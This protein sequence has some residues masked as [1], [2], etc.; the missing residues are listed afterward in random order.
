MVR[1]VP[2]I[3]VRIDAFLAHAADLPEVVSVSSPSM[4]GGVSEDGTVAYA[5]V[6]YA[7]AASDVATESVDALTGLIDSSDGDGLR[8]ETGGAVITNTERS[9]PGES[10]LISIAAA[11]IILLLTFGSVVA[12]G[13]PIVTALIGVAIG[14]AL[15]AISAA[16]LDMATLTTAF[17]S[18][19]GWA[20]HPR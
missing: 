19:P 4:S 14:F 5:T 17:T 2:A 13:L 9:V 3:Q 8:I 20:G 16:F 15:T 6:Q 12:M 18:S 11:V 7:E 10:E 1:A